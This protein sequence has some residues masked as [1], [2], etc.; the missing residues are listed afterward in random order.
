MKKVANLMSQG[1]SHFDS[2]VVNS[3]VF[4]AFFDTFKRSFTRILRRLD[5]NEIEFNKG[6]F[7]ISGFFKVDTGCFYFS[8]SDVR[9]GGTKM[10]IRTAKDNKDFTGGVNRYVNVNGDVASQISRL[11]KLKL[12]KRPVAGDDS[13][14]IAKR[15][16]DSGDEVEYEVRVTSNKRACNIAW[17][18]MDLLEVPFKNKGIQTY[19]YT[20][21]VISHSVCTFSGFNFYYS[22]SSK[23]M[24]IR[25]NKKEI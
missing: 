18:L 15:I 12:K 22:A 7:Y 24:I 1:Y 16:F 25:Y 3:E 17:A 21:G 14:A 6:H 9:D 2:G 13:A 4:N 23:R 20:G 5:A 19:K 11:F 10:L 8:I